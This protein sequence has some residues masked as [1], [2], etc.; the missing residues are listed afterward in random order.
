MVQVF[1]YIQ[2]KKDKMKERKNN[3]K[4]IN[5]NNK[6]KNR[7]EAKRNIDNEL[8]IIEHFYTRIRCILYAP[9][10]YFST[11]EF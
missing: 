8:K 1:D 4:K 7:F 9:I 11:S 5:S 2:R 10:I 6:N 3:K